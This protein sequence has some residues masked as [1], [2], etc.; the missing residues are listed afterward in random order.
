MRKTLSILTITALM[1]FTTQVPAQC[2]YSF[3]RTTTVSDR[4]I[5]VTINACSTDV[6]AIRTG[7]PS[8]AYELGPEWPADSKAEIE[9]TFYSDDP[10]T[11]T[12]SPHLIVQSNCSATDKAGR[13][14][15]FKIAE[16]PTNISADRPTKDEL[17]RWSASVPSRGEP[18]SPEAIEMW[19]ADLK[20]L[21]KE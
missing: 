10:V 12:Y 11:R 7:C 15:Q 6:I 1:V 18:S 21:Y 16:S 13:P 20:P 2:I 9:K 17:R 8:P 4:R 14:V 19:I 3:E 5:I